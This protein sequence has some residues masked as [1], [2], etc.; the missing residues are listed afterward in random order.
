MRAGDQ[1]RHRAVEC[2]RAVEV[3]VEKPR[4]IALLEV[5]QRWLNLAEQA[6]LAGENSLLAWR[7]PTRALH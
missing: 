6:D 1:Y 4:K 3:V 2:M 7:S 5:A